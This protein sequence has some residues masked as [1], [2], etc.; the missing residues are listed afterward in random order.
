MVKILLLLFIQKIR[1]NGQKHR[2]N[3]KYF[4]EQFKGK[5]ETI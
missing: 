4:S 1:G 2:K 5:N 3:S